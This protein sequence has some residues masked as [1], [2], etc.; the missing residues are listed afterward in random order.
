MI[1]IDVTNWTGIP[2]TNSKAVQIA[3]AV[4]TKGRRI[5]KVTNGSI[6]DAVVSGYFQV[7]DVLKSEGT[8]NGKQRIEVECFWYGKKPPSSWM[9][10][11]INGNGCEDVTDYIGEV[12]SNIGAKK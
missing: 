7:A 8:Y 5:I 11:T 4:P 12:I 10:L 2:S 3:H 6:R 9:H 1:S